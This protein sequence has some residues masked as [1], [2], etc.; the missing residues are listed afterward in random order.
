MAESDWMQRISVDPQIHS[1]EPC[2]RGTRI[3]AS[4]V[5]GSIADG[6]DF[7]TLMKSYPALTTEDIRAC[8]RYAAEALR[9]SHLLPLGG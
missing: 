8:L 1:G 4:I 6:D 5:V 3:P 9:D 2:V 7:A